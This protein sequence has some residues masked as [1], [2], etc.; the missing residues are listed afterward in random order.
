[1]IGN[2]THTVRIQEP[3]SRVLRFIAGVSILYAVWSQRG[4]IAAWIFAGFQGDAGFSSVTGVVLPLLV[5]FV[6]AVGGFGIFAA[7]FGWGVLADIVSGIYATLAAWRVKAALAAGIQTA[8]GAASSA[9]QTIAGTMAGGAATTT[10]AANATQ[11]AQSAANY[12][13]PPPT[14]QFDLVRFA[15]QVQSTLRQQREAISNIAATVQ[16]L[17]KRASAG[18]ALAPVAPVS[19]T[20]PR[21]G[22]K[23]TA[24]PTHEQITGVAS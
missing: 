3:P 2:T 11:A 12:G 18:A 7:S 17:E 19:P 10:A 16:K 24:A 20:A 9:A 6:I 4:Q 21:R 22:R 23:P 1:M 13:L 15:E 14:E 8:I 5:E